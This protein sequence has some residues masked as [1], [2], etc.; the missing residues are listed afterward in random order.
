VLPGSGTTDVSYGLREREACLLKWDA[1]MMPERK[2]SITWCKD[3]KNGLHCL[4][5]DATDALKAPKS[6][7][8]VVNSVDGGA[9]DA[10]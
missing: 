6:W 3:S 5:T 1:L 7:V 2:L 4:Q 8:Q 10:C 9:R